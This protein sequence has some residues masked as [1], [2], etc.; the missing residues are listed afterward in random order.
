MNHRWKMSSMLTC[1][2]LSLV[3]GFAPADSFDLTETPLAADWGAAVS[4]SELSEQRGRE[5]LSVLE[6]DDLLRNELTGTT[7][8]N[9][10]HSSHN[11]SNLIDNGSFV[12]ANGHVTVFQNTG[13]NNVFQEATIYHFEIIP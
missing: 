11:G 7:T 6:A 9:V 2:S 8:G 5:G 13:H 3:S 10:V 12:G 1:V 4:F